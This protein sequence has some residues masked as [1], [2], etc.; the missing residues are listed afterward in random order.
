MWNEWTFRGLWEGE[1][2][3]QVQSEVQ[4][5]N[6]LNGSS[7]KANYGE[8]SESYKTEEQAISRN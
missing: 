1:P 3:L 7:R 6:L 5:N 4:I 8:D 2:T